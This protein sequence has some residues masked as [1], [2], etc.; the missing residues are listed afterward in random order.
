MIE[1]SRESPCIVRRDYQPLTDRFHVQQA[2]TTAPARNLPH[3]II[4]DGSRHQVFE[5]RLQQAKEGWN[6]IFQQQTQRKTRQRTEIRR[7]ILTNNNQQ[8]NAPWG[9]PLGEKLASVTRIYS[10][11]LNGIALDKRGGQFDT[12][13]TIAKELQVD[14]LCGQE[15]NV[16]TTQSEVR[17]ILYNTARQ[18]WPRSRLVT[19]STATT[20]ANWYKPGGTLQLSIG[21]ITGR[22]TSTYQ[23]P[24]GRWVSQTFRGRDGVQLTVISA[25][26][27]VESGSQTGKTTA[28][29]QQT[30]QLTQMN[31]TDCN[32]RRAFKHDLRS[33]L[34]ECSAR[35]DELLLLGDFNES[36]DGNFNG[37]SRIITDFFLVDLMKLRSN[38][39][40]PATYSRGRLRLD[41]GLATR[42][43]ADA[44]VTAGYESFN[45][46]FPT[47][48]RAYYF[49][50]DTE[51]L[52]GAHT[53]ALAIPSLRLMHS[54]NVKQVTQYIQEKY[55]QLEQ[56][57][58]FGRGFQLTMPGNRHSFAERLDRDI[59]QASLTA[60]KKVKAFQA[61]AWSVS[62]IKAREKVRILKKGLFQLRHGMD[63]A[64]TLTMAK[65]LGV[66]SSDTETMTQQQCSQQLR[67]AKREVKA[68]IAESF[69]RREDELQQKLKQHEQ[70]VHE[71]DK[72]K[73]AILK[74]IMRA[75]ALK[76]LA[77]K[78]RRLRSPD[79]RQGITRVEI[80]AHPLDD[81]KSCT[82]W[83][84]IDVPSEIV[85]HLQN[86]NRMHFG[87]AHGTPFTVP[88]LSNLLGFS[89][90]GEHAEDILTRGS[91]DYPDLDDNV[92]LLLD[93]LRISEEM[94][95]Q[96]SYPTITEEE[97][98][99]KLKVW[100][101][102]TT[103]SPSGVHLG[104]YKALI[105]P[106][107]YT[108]INDDDD[109]TEDGIKRTELRD[110]LNGMQ[111]AIRE[112]HLQVI[113]YA[114]ERGYSYQ[115]WQCVANTMLF[116]EKH[117]IR[118]HRTRVIHIYEADYNLML[119]LKWRMALYQSEALQQLNAG[120]YGSR[121][122]RNAI[123]PVMLEELQFEISRLSRK[124]FLQTN[125]DATACY[126]RIIPNLATLA[127]RRFGVDQQVALTNA[128]TLEQARY[129][130]RTEMGLS[131][132]SY[133]HS[134]SFPIYGTGQG[135]GNSP[136][137]WCFVSSLLF[138]CYETRAHPAA[139]CN[140]DRTNQSHW[141][142]I[143]FVDDMNGQ[144]NDF[145]ASEHKES[146]PLIHRCTQENAMIWAQLLGVTGGLLE[147]QKC[148][149]HVM[150]WKFTIHGAPV[151]ATCSHEHRQLEVTN[152]VTGQN[153]SL[154]YLPPHTAHKTLGH[155]KEPAGTQTEQYRQLH[156]KSNDITHFLWSSPVSRAETLMF[157][158]ACYLPS[159]CYPLTCS[160]FTRQQLDTIQ[161][162]AMAIIIARSGYN[163]NTKKAV[164]YGPI[165][166]GGAR[167]HH[168]YDKQGIQQVE[169]FI[170]HWR[171]QTEV[172]KMLKCTIAWAQ[173][174]VGVSYSILANP[175]STLPHFESKWLKSIR[176]YL[177][178]IHASIELDNPCVPQIQRRGDSYIMDH[179][180]ES[181]QFSPMEIRHIN[182]CRL[183]L[184]A[185]TVSDLAV[186]NGER[187]DNS[188]YR[189][190]PSLQS[191]RTTWL[192]VHQEK[193]SEKAWRTWRRANLLWSHQDGRLKVPLQEWLHETTRLRNRYAAYRFRSRVWI[194]Q[195]EGDKYME[196]RM[197]TTNI[198]EQYPLREVSFNQ[199]PKEVTPA[200]IR[201]K[202]SGAWEVSG[203]L[204]PYRY[205][206][207]VPP[208]RVATFDMY[209]DTLDPWEKDLLQHHTLFA[210]AFT[211]CWTA[212]VNLRVVSDG[213]AHPP[214]KASFGWMM[215][216][217]EGE[218]A[219]QGMGPVRGRTLHSYRAEATG[220][221]SALRFL[222]RLREFCQ[223]HERWT[224]IVATDS[225]SLLDTL[226]GETSLDENRNVPV[227][228]DFNRVVLDVLSPE[229]DILIEIQRSLQKLPG[230]RLE[231]VEGHQD[232]D[233]PYENLS[234]LAQ[235]NVDADRL[236]SEYNDG[237]SLRTPFAII[238]PN[239]RA[240]LVFRDG[241]VTSKYAET[242]EMEATGPPLKEYL[243][244]RNNWTISTFDNIDWTVHGATLKR[245][246]KRR[247]HLIKFLHDMLPTNGRLN[248][249]DGGKRTCPLCECTNEDRDHIMRC[250]HT[251]RLEWRQGCITK[252]TEY[253]QITNTYPHLTRLLVEGLE[254]WLAGNDAP[255]IALDGYPLDLHA[256][257]RQQNKVGW[258]QVMLGRFVTEWRRI[259]ARYSERITQPT[260]ATN[261]EIQSKRTPEQWLI[262]LISVLW[263]QWYLLWDDRNHDLHGRDAQQRQ[264]QLRQEVQRQLR[265]IYAKQQFMDPN[266]RALLLRDPEAHNTQ[267]LQVTVNWLRMNAPIFRENIKKVR[268]MALKGV[269][270]IRTYFHPLPNSDTTT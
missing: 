162:R 8:F 64:D 86:R 27:V 29:S 11:N 140:P 12:L 185:I 237:Y 147:L 189:G 211:I 202:T 16:D 223:M 45:E 238:S 54:T 182:Y 254:R 262:G 24:L 255:S 214:S 114:L 127:S 53:Q 263:D 118:I 270:S 177:D 18:H 190:V 144:A 218:R 105:A 113:N 264:S 122:R 107:E 25:Y 112:L 160:H 236:A 125:Y 171:E 126:D 198:S 256:V 148:S 88:P 207:P 173:L 21:H 233:V 6:S 123:D 7:T 57:N 31:V 110:E 76:K 79:I 151:L 119:G 155:Y 35:G 14:I 219:A 81:P 141:Y 40:P 66:F 72:K 234:L 265:E 267:S 258:N 235:L 95:E 228:L 172:G 215:S 154:T 133:T 193:P 194:R 225:Q 39:K 13:C 102:T 68:I 5:Q 217:R 115:R 50:L 179:V 226:A 161:R 56:S 4:D 3:D 246:K 132:T 135:S 201:H 55:K 205:P 101:E 61:P 67:Q 250:H 253:C 268:R 244:T 30:S 104:H 156:N 9:D 100:K 232:R 124:T 199:L 10:L 196:Y 220:M 243:Q 74:R 22:I 84:I 17:N 1:E 183:Y 59:L 28:A 176:T 229:W 2:T 34:R 51:K 136:M 209:V 240:H 62:L 134:A 75:E 159:I 37:M 48:H 149:Y 128:R 83:R 15:H 206:S 251:S 210:D 116:K 44:L 231:Y 137:I 175:A 242:I 241:T 70:S 47:D 65:N 157:Y 121:P 120:Q 169:Y 227:D 63:Y 97:F 204:A 212:Q 52:F 261:S 138:Q 91:C 257:I 163:R 94:A 41:Y 58:A 85:T 216:N 38:Q 203:H 92:K 187:L 78:I 153:Q 139:Y 109:C 69:T 82:E 23:D 224:G 178:S 164:L 87:Q 108:H 26:Q 184:Q 42:R 165:E 252:V 103:T 221:L 106:H 167:F 245:M 89:G 152:P 145:F 33:Y 99:G 260:R 181:R 266:V 247:S 71:S 188:K 46:R 93:H 186:T 230:V 130:I 213:S 259:Q 143:G 174:N 19:G 98:I 195:A 117:N 180:L 129:F 197:Q 73:A 36:I 43:V 32:P 111:K 166:F 249:F 142:M 239:V 80:P 168:L 49:D 131:P 248:R 208:S 20:F 60:E 90:E 269:R 191:S 150:S 222:I 200:E 146:L 96:E 170:R 192:E 158:N 77:E